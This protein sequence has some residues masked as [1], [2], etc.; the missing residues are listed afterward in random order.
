M[1]F[2]W[3]EVVQLLL[4][5]LDGGNI[6]FLLRNQVSIQMSFHVH[7]ITTSPHIWLWILMIQIMKTYLATLL[8]IKERR[9]NPIPN[10][11]L[12]DE[13][14]E[15][16]PN[17]DSS[18]HTADSMVEQN[19]QFDLRRRMGDRTTWELPILTLC[20]ISTTPSCIAGRNHTAVREEHK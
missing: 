4:E 16:D 14:N 1:P 9:P 10:L 7:C 18:H 8:F 11:Q 19:K 6:D 13:S 3:V 2:N 20:I 12:V 17:N 15:D 5:D